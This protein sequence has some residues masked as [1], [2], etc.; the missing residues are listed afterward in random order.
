MEGGFPHITHIKLNVSKVDL[1]KR[2]LFEV[3][4]GV[5]NRLIQNLFRF[6]GLVDIEG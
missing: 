5:G 4:G 2:T 1:E 3:A 6:F